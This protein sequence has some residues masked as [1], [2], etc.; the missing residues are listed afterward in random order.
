MAALSVIREQLFRGSECELELNPSYVM[1][2][3]EHRLI[4]CHSVEPISDD[5]ELCTWT[6]DAKGYKDEWSCLDWYRRDIDLISKPLLTWQKVYRQF[7]D[8]CK[9][10]EIVS[11]NSQPPSTGN[12]LED[13]C[14]RA[15]SQSKSTDDR[16]PSWKVEFSTK[17]DDED[18]AQHLA[19]LTLPL[20]ALVQIYSLYDEFGRQPPYIAFPEVRPSYRRIYLSELRKQKRETVKSERF[21]SSLINQ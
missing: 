16:R 19:L 4:R 11:G 12:W 1:R 18:K 10:C 2:V 9:W 3:L 8:Q 7:Y 20:W 15:R 5:D 21:L 6:G 17:P 14:S 13:I